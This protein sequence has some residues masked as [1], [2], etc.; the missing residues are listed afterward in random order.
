MVEDFALFFLGGGYAGW[1]ACF[2]AVFFQLWNVEHCTH[3]NG[4]GVRIFCL[5]FFV[6]VN[7]EFIGA[8]VFAAHAIE[9]SARFNGVGGSGSHICRGWFCSLGLLLFFLGFLLFLFRLFLIFFRFLLLLV[10]FLLVGIS[11]GRV[12]G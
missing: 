2:C 12:F 10:S 8:I 5:V 3:W 11:F 9:V 4:V 6:D 1:V 7:P